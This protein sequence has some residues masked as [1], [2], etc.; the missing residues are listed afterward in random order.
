M[1]SEH[2]SDITRTIHFEDESAQVAFAARVANHLKSEF[3]MLLN[4]DLGTGKTTFARGFIHGSGFD[5]LV[6]SPTYTLVE[7]YAIS[8]KRTC[9]HFDLYRLAEPEELE[10]IGAR[11]YFN[12]TDVCL[13][14]W[15]EK[16][17]GFLPPADWDCE[18]EYLNRGRNLT[19]SA[20]SDKGKELMLLVFSD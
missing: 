9:Y 5:G 17:A 13:I 14:E 18:F 12:E 3:V 4:G 16:A 15:P 8:R 1:L 10:F 20:L 11:D 7:P 6:K 19:V 2:Q